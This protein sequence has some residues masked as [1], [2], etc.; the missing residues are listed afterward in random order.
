MKR[1]DFIAFFGGA[2]AF[3]AAARAREP[4]WTIG[5]LGSASYDSAFPVTE[6]AFIEGLRAVGFIE[7]KNMS[8]EWRWAGGQ[9]DRLSSLAGELVSRDVADLGGRDATN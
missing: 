5:V 3:V 9:Y 7:G 6:R 2:T 4:R 8:V 1:R